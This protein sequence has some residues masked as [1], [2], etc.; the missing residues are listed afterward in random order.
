MKEFLYEKRE[1]KKGNRWKVNWLKYRNHKILENIER[2]EASI[3][4]W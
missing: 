4:E 3:K 1:Y 2:K